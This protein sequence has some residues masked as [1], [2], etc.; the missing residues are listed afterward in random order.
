MDY[1]IP[2]ARTQLEAGLGFKIEINP[3][4]ESGLVIWFDRENAVRPATGVE[5]A[6]WR[7]LTI[8]TAQSSPAGVPAEQVV[9]PFGTPKE[10]K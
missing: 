7:A 10:G 2:Q 6:L 5:V 1:K 9:D 3:N 8:A 4:G